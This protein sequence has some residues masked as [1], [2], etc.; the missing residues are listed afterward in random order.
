MKWI[1]METHTHTVHSDA[2]YT[3][4]DLL[5]A[6]G[7]AGLDAIALTDHNTDT[8]FDEI[9]AGQTAPRVV[10]GIEWTTFFGHVVVIAPDGFVEWRDLSKDNLDAHLRQVHKQNGVAVMAHP[11]I[12][13]EPFCCGC[14]WDFDIPDYGQI[15]AIEVWSEGDPD[16]KPWN[17][18]AYWTWQKKIAEGFRI[19]ALTARDWH[20]DDA[21]EVI[22]GV[23]YLYID[24][25]KPF[26]EAVKDALRGGRS[27]LTA[28]PVL[29]FEVK[30]D[31]TTAGIGETAA[32]GTAEISVGAFDTARRSIWDA[33]ELIPESF[34]IKNL[35]YR[36]GARHRLE[37]PF[38]AYGAVA[39]VTAEVFP[40][41]LFVELI[42]TAHGKR[43]K[44]ALTNPVWVE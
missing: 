32:A 9:A 34:V 30:T 11:Y 6:A 13:G 22:Y 16:L 35:E 23:N 31:G 36:S 41:P 3:V 20:R 27:Y 18:K 25:T 43:C 29:R 28:G 24:E 10:P 7:K 21:P 14:H 5:R 39:E 44:L 4:N 17:Q 1:C 12:A 42:G 15:D 19:T 40:G 37:I 26:A 38:T 8:G 2:S 33:Y